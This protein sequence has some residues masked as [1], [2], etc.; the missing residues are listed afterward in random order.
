[1]LHALERQKSPLVQIMLIDWLVEN[2]ERQA[3]NV[4]TRMSDE[5][6][7]QPKVRERA[8]WGLRQLS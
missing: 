3:I 6:K 2:K 5:P 4:L 8:R 7:V 1:L